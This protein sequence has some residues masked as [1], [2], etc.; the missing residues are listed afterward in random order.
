MALLVVLSALAAVHFLSGSRLRTLPVAAVGGARFDP[1]HHPDA[2]RA[3]ELEQRLGP[4]PRPRGGLRLGAVLKYFGN[5]YWQLLAEGMDERARQLGVRLDIRAAASED[6]Q[7]G[8]R[9][10]AMDLLDR[11]CDVLL[12]SPQTDLNL[13][14]VVERA[15][16]AGVIVLNVNDAVLPDAEHWVGPNQRDNG[17]R[18]GRWLR[19]RLPQGGTVALV[20]GLAGV[21]AV[22]QRSGGFLASL[23]GGNLRVVAD[24]HGDWELDRALTVAGGML[25]QHP[26][27]AAIYCNNDTMALGVAE[28][29]RRAGAQG[30]VL[31]A[32]TDGIAEAHRAIADGRLA[33]T[34]DSFPRLTGRWA[35]E[36]AVRLAAG[37]AVPRAVYTPQ[38]LIAR[39][40][41]EVPPG[42]EAPP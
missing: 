21:Y 26:D 5:P 12:V 20:R 40:G 2:C 35:V 8:Q 41:G 6:D 36:V 14:P 38:A 31:V 3:E 34:V 9:R 7:E 29:V 27:L 17:V 4:L 19:E 11:G 30:R 33:A 15:R 22:D 28:A 37:Q 24:A 25:A 42:A 23:A 10:T 13:A 1:D 18:V 32:G 39:T 16:R